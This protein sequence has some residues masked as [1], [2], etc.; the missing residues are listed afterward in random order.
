VSAPR[1]SICI[2]TVDRL[3]YLRESVASAQ[4]Q[5]LCELEIVIGDDGDSHELR[6]WVLGTAAV[7]RRVRYL[8]TPRRLGMADTWNFLSDRAAGEFL[9]LIGDDDRLLPGFAERLLREVTREVAVVFSNHYFIDEAGRRLIDMSLGGTHQYGRDALSPGL[10][11]NAALAV[12]RNSVPM[13]SCIVRTSEV[14]RLRFR[15]D[16]NTPEIELFARLSLEGR[17]FVFVPEYLAE[18]RSHA[19]SETAR[20]L[21]LDRLA[22]YLEAIEVPGDVEAAKRACLERVLA[23]GVGIR[24]RRGDIVGARRLCSSRYYPGGLSSLVQRVSLGLPDPLAAGTYAALRRIGRLTRGI[25]RR[26]ASR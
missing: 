15:S 1:I 19:K 7:D 9:T 3:A 8:K 22:E 13:S 24:L 21:T 11:A 18:Y 17:H 5:H 10:L 2:P 23:A 4:L 16:I 20:G 26:A 14:R 25:A 6:E 12:W